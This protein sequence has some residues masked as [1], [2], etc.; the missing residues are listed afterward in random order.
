MGE[1][2]FYQWL[3]QQDKRD[4]RVGDLARDAQR[5]SAWPKGA[6]SA[7]PIERHLN[8]VNACAGALRSL[9]QAWGEFIKGTVNESGFLR[10]RRTR[11]QVERDLQTVCR[12]TPVRRAEFEAAKKRGWI[13][14]TTINLRFAWRLWCEAENHPCVML[15]GKRFKYV[16]LQ[17]DLERFQHGAETP[18]LNEK[19]AG[20]IAG[21]IG[22]RSW[23]PG[24]YIEVAIPREHAERVAA[25]LVQIVRECASKG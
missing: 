21:L 16:R 10:P 18:E 22:G 17:M 6:I 25:E 4:D 2:T 14:G 3:R 20:L 12:L 13:W 24:R 1:A 5:D 23:A 7:E 9:E 19:I 15:N 8:G 11:E